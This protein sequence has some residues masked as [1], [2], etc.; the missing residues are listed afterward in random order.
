MLVLQALALVVLLQNGYNEYMRQRFR[1]LAVVAPS[2]RTLLATGLPTTGPNSNSPTARGSHQIA[3]AA[4]APHLAESMLP[5]TGHALSSQGIVCGPESTVAPSIT[6]KSM[7]VKLAHLNALVEEFE[8][9]QG[10]IRFLLA[11]R[12][13]PAK[14]PYGIFGMLQ[15]YCFFC[16]CCTRK[17]LREQHAATAGSNPAIAG[18]PATQS[19]PTLG[20]KRWEDVASAEPRI[21][22]KIAR[23]RAALARQREMGVDRTGKT[24]VLPGQSKLPADERL[25]RIAYADT[26]F[27]TFQRPGV[28][29]HGLSGRRLHTGTGRILGS[30]HGNVASAQPHDRVYNEVLQAYGI[31]STPGAVHAYSAPDPDDIVWSNMD[32]TRKQRTIRS[33]IATVL[34][35][36][37]LIIAFA[38]AV[39]AAALTSLGPLGQVIGFLEP[40]LNWGG[41]SKGLIQSLLPALLVTVFLALLL[42]IVRGTR[43]T[44]PTTTHLSSRRMCVSA[45]NLFELRL[46]PGCACACSHRQV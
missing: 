15:R 8:V 13:D 40:V 28:V 7:D 4:A 2:Q 6:G 23:L 5:N 25:H 17:G 21:A 46:L 14:K 24:V 31:T 41:L 32:L 34:L 44:P 29:Q 12:K 3:A 33:F 11:T 16:C 45:R 27:V 42:M 38:P 35:T 10:Q 43:C 26:A 19:A 9:L 1:W 30:A 18:A 20:D 37:V 22:R 36:I 39:F